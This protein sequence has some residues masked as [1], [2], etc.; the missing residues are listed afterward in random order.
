[1]CDRI[2]RKI[3]DLQN[4]NMNIEI[5]NKQKIKI[6]QQFNFVEKQRE[7]TNDDVSIF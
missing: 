4:I 7:Q 1:M 2:S 3:A 6:N 5:L